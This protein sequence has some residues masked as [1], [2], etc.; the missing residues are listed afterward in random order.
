MRIE[1]MN[2]YLT[3]EN[4]LLRNSLL[5]KVA[6]FNKIVKP[7]FNS[8]T[9]TKKDSPKEYFALCSLHKIYSLNISIENSLFANDVFTSIYFYRYIYELYLKVYYIFSGSSEEQ[10][11]SRLNEFFENVKWNIK[12]IKD[13]INDRFLP[14]RFKGSHEEKYKTICRFVHPNYESFKLHLN[15]TDNQQFEFLVSNVNLTL[16]HSI[17]IV[18]FFSNE[19]LLGFDKKINQRNLNSLQ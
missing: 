9:V 12:D 11:L 5:I 3:S 7:G 14:Q 18:K 4:V 15:R 6:S 17:E 13:K 19:K 10:V 16:W 1:A 2:K 8:R